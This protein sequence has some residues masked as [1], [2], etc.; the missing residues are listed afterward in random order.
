MSPYNK[1]RTTTHEVGHWLDLRH[2]W[3]DKKGSFGTDYVSDTSDQEEKTLGTASFPK[4]DH[5]IQVSPGVMFM[6]YMDYTDDA[7]LNLFTKGQVERMLALFKSQNGIRKE[8]LLYADALTAPTPP[9]HLWTHCC[10]QSE[11]VHHQVFR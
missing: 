7:C 2:I 10:L 5:C 11:C 9:L 3:G 8:M 1:G 4:T 6:N